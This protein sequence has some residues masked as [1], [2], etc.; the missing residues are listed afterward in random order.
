MAEAIEKKLRPCEMVATSHNMSFADFSWSFKVRAGSLVLEDQKEQPKAEIFSVGYFLDTPVHEKERPITFAFNGGPGASSIWVHF[1][2]MG[3]WRISFGE[4]IKQPAPPYYFED[5]P[6][7]WLAFTDIVFVDAPGTGFSRALGDTEPKSHWG[8]W[9]DAKIFSEFIRLY[10]STYDRW[11][12][13]KYIAGESYGGL[14]SVAL[15]KELQEVQGMELSGLLLISPVVDYQTMANC[16]GNHIASACFL[17]S[18]AATAHHHQCLSPQMQDKSLDTVLKEAE[19]FAINEYLPSLAQGTAIS[20]DR[21]ATCVRKLTELIGLSEKFIKGSHLTVDCVRFR[22]ELLRHRGRTV[23]RFDSRL[24]GS[25]Y[26]GNSERPDYDPSD[27]LTVGPFVGP[28]N[29]LLK[30]KFGVKETRTYQIQNSEVLK[31]WQ[32]HPKGE[33]SYGFVNLTP[34]LRCQIVTNERLRVLFVSGLYDIATP[35]YAARYTM[36]SLRL[37]GEAKERVSQLVYPGG[38]MVYTDQRNHEKLSADIR[39]YYEGEER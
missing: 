11:L 32:W 19:E 25:D 28:F 16:P 22:K 3:P 36:N 12:S 35:Y 29:D 37:A 34:E 15:C 10:C 5:N 26:D 8:V 21:R 23:G 14:R 7:S 2:S 17:P 6:H 30:S 9:E 24:V 33:R 18:Y 31:D 38:H 20:A 4:T 27:C 1:G 39:A 13:P